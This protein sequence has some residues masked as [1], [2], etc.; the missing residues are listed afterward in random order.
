MVYGERDGYKMTS[1]INAEIAA[2]LAEVELSGKNAS[3]LVE[4]L[5]GDEGDEDK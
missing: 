2:F 3:D 4:E 5:K 1:E